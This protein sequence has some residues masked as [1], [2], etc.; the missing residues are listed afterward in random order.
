MPSRNTKKASD[1][2]VLAILTGRGKN[3]LSNKNVRPV[4]GKPILYYPAVA[5]YKSR[6]VDGC[7]VSSDS[8]KILKTATR[9]GFFPIKRPQALAKPNAQHEDAIKHALKHIQDK[10]KKNP[11]ILVI[12]LANSV[13]IKTKWIDDCITMIID[14]PSLT[15]VIPVY[16]DSDHHPFRSKK[17]NKDNLLEPFFD[18]SG[19]RISTNRQDLEPSYF[20]C[21]NF[22]VIRTE[23]LTRNLGQ[24]PWRFMGDKIKPYIIEERT[25]DVHDMEDIHI[26]ERWLK[27]NKIK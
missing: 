20:P 16:K 21:H 11:N 23:N 5:A 9:I 15:S 1:H 12:L 18:F 7:F 8:N 13:T 14:D 3:T 19:L 6:L 25:M 4:L 17:I 27:R 22:W 26:S 2:V 10:H 24:E